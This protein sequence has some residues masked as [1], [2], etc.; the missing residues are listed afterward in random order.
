MS[1][2]I[3]RSLLEVPAHLSPLEIYIPLPPKTNICSGV[4]VAK[5]KK[6]PSQISV[7]PRWDSDLHDYFITEILKPC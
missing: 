6:T 2:I 7:M 5:K 3:S 4:G 1:N